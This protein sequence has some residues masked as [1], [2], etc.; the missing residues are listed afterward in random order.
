MNANSQSNAEAA[1]TIDQQHLTSPGTALGTVAYMSPE[2]ARGKELDSRTDLF[3]FGAV[4]YEMSTGTLPFRGDTTA[5]LFESILHKAPVAPVRLN[6]DLP[7]EL[8]RILNTALEK[9]RELRYQHAADL[10]ADLKRL[11]RQTESGRAAVDASLMYEET[12]TAAAPS[13]RRH[14]PA[15]VSVPGVAAAGRLGRWKLIVPTLVLIAAVG[16]TFLWHSRRARGLSEKDLILL[17]DFTNTT[18]DPVFDGTLKTALQVSLAQS[19]FLNLVPQPDVAQTL[20]LMGK[21]ADTR[22]TPDIGREICQRKGIKAM[23]HGSIA[24]LGSAYV[25][26][27]DAVNASTGNSIAQEQSQAEG[28]EKVL[29]ALGQAG[30]SLREKLGESLASV[31]QFDKPL[32]EATTSSLEAL[33][34]NSEAADHNN[35]GDSL[36]GL[37][38]S[39][40]AIELDEFCH[41]LSRAGR[42][43]REHGPVR[44]R[45]ELH[46]QGLRV[47]GPCQ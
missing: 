43:I 24:S 12:A 16:G 18:G 2:Q 5:N 6:P 21:P 11:K 14:S 28:K 10:R 9:D 13:S 44:N 35:N 45:V 25:V 38:F 42:G 33:K 7:A 19:P 15:P 36:R 29:A 8:E 22:V 41:G 27:V 4:L 37:E 23:V 40:R 3:S 39:K 20:K 30:T 17:T 32:Q 46:P 47:E 26:T 1:A 34:M 31:Q